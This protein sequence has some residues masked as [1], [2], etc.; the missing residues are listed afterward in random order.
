MHTMVGELLAELLAGQNVTPAIIASIFVLA[1]YGAVKYGEQTWGTNPTSWSYVKYA[2]I[3]IVALVVTAI[4]Y[5]AT[6]VL[7]VAT[8][9]QINAWLGPAFETLGAAVALLIGAKYT[10]KVAEKKALTA[11]SAEQPKPG[12]DGIESY[13]AT[14]TPAFQEVKSPSLAIVKIACSETVAQY[15]I[16]WKDGTPITVGGFTHEGEYYVATVGH[17]YSYLFDGKYDSH[18]FYPEITI[19]GNDGDKNVFNTEGKG[20]SVSILV[21]K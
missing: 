8:V 19:I 6:G 17:L 5:L 18:T 7:G 4:G 10:I 9:E 2:Q 14:F 20:R 3:F 1:M 11:N 13:G 12:D 15:M 16:D 21:W